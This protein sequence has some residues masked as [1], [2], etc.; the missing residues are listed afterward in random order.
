MLRRVTFHIGRELSKNKPVKKSKTADKS[1]ID[2]GRKIYQ[3]KS[4]K[5]CD[6]KIK[7]K[8]AKSR[9]KPVGMKR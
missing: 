3:N 8:T 9:S 7:K 5:E 1:A 6:E 2:L 4:V